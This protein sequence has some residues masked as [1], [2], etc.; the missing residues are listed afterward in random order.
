[1]KKNR[2]ITLMVL[3]F[4]IV[5]IPLT[6]NMV[7]TQKGDIRSWAK[8]RILVP[9]FFSRVYRN[10]QSEQSNQQCAGNGQYCDTSAGNRSSEGVH[11]CDP[12]VP[13]V[14]HIC[15]IPS[16]NTGSLCGRPQDIPCCDNYECTPDPNAF[17]APTCVKTCAVAGEPC[18]ILPCCEDSFCS[19]ATGHCFSSSGCIGKGQFCD[20]TVPCCDPEYD[21]VLSKGVCSRVRVTPVILPTLAPTPTPGMRISRGGT[22]P[23]TAPTPIPGTSSQG[24]MNGDVNGDGKVDI[25]DIGIIIDNYGK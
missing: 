3:A 14:S 21:C 17:F 16:C 20:G 15:T 23:F 19:G 25:V 10:L 13:C 22:S 9:D 2:I 18:N 6:V 1:M 12:R 7:L 4:S 24:C 8:M 5:L 11:C